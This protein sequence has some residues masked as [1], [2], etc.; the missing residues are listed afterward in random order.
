MS[1]YPNH[2]AEFLMCSNKLKM[3]R[4]EEKALKKKIDKIQPILCTWLKSQPSL[5]MKL[6]FDNNQ[7]AVFGECGKLKFEIEKR[8]EY[9]SKNNLFGYLK[10]FFSQ[11]FP[12]KS[13]K[14][15]DEISL[16]A[17]THIWQ[18]RK[19]TKHTASVVRTFSK[20]RKHSS[21]I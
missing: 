21:R 14:Y 13:E 16:A 6:D 12:Q 7:S 20:K 8:K 15:I 1:S 10:S 18:S 4:E 11:L 3:L 9:L 2:V 5:E 19:T 17:S